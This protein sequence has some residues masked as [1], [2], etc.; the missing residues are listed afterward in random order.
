MRETHNAQT[1]IFEH[2]SNHGHGI[3]LQELSKVLDRHPEI[4]DLVAEDLINT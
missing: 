3:Q 4:L 2:Y 1:S